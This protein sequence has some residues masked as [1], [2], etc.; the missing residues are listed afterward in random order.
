[1]IKFDEMSRA[2]FPDVR[3]LFD[4]LL[5]ESKKLYKKRLVSLAIFGSHAG[6]RKSPDSDIDIL[7]V[8]EG[9][10]RRRLA[11]VGEFEKIEE[12]L[13]GDLRKLGQI[14]INTYFS[15]IFKTPEEVKRG[16]LLFLDMVYDVLILY[17]KDSFFSNYLNDFKTRLEKLGARR[18][19]RGEK[20]YWILKPD[21]KPGET[22]EI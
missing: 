6:K 17:D 12:V 8:A 7:V 10:S 15:P 3:P 4:R 21:Y 1:M 9:L 19:Q 11:R 5:T 18:V 22:F 20:W 16:S 2:S 13:E 14:G